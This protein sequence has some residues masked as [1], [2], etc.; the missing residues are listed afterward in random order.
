MLLHFACEAGGTRRGL[1]V[2]PL[3]AASSSLTAAAW[4]S[5][6]A[7]AGLHFTITGMYPCNTDS[8]YV[9]SFLVF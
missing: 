7:A 5:K 6:T 3:I 4:H 9:E 8:D 1:K 2:A